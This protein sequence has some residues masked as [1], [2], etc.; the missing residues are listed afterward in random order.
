MKKIGHWTPTS[1]SQARSAAETPLQFIELAIARPAPD[2]A[3]V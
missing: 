3:D 1:Q 2:A